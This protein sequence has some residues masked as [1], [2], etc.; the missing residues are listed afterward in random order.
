MARLLLWFYHLAI[1]WAGYKAV[2]AVVQWAKQSP[3]QVSSTGSNLGQGQG[4][5]PVELT[6]NT[7][8]TKDKRC[9]YEK[10]KICQYE[11]DEICQ[12]EKDKRC[13]NEKDKRKVQTFL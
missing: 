9:Q 4:G 2:V 6:C 13:Q 5:N 12:N 10:D 8:M 1:H 3:A 11:K 7:T